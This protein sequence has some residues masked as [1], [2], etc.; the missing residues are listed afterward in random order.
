MTDSSAR[1]RNL[2]TLLSVSTHFHM[3]GIFVVWVL[4]SSTETLSES[5]THERLRGSGHTCISMVE[6]ILHTPLALSHTARGWPECF[7]PCG[8]LWG[9]CVCVSQYSILCAFDLPG[10]NTLLLFELPFFTSVPAEGCKSFHL[11][12]YCS[13]DEACNLLL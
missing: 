1:F 4:S 5:I 7:S 10:P 12:S 3:R 2:C 8:A 13:Q 6:L 11:T 9:E